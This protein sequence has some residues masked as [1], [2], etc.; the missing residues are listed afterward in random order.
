MGTLLLATWIAL[1]RVDSPDAIPVRDPAVRPVSNIA[2]S[3]LDEAARRS[4]TVSA[5]IRQLRQYDIIVYVDLDLN[6]TRD[7]GTTRILTATGNWRILR[8]A[9]SNT[10]DPATRIEVLGHELCHALEIARAPEVRD[11]ATFKTFYERVGF[12]VG[13]ASFE[14]SEARDMEARVRRDLSKWGS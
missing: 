9:L 5:L 12:G 3:I 10:L 11:A 14:T 7:R 2:R 6:M 1:A 8:V 4:P 13:P